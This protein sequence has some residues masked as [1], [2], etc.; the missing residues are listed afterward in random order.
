MACR[1]DGV[2]DPRV[3]VCAAAAVSLRRP[4]CLPVEDRPLDGV[5]SLPAGRVPGVNEMFRQHVP[6]L[7]SHTR[8]PTHVALAAAHE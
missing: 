7:A 8:A 6:R 2:Q 3:V 1:S 4:P 5:G